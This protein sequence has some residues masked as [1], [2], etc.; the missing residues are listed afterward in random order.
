MT[1][2]P[3]RAQLKMKLQMI[4]P[5]KLIHK[6]SLQ[7]IGTV[8]LNCLK[9]PMIFFQ[10][11]WNAIRCRVVLTF[12]I[13]LTATSAKISISNNSELNIPLYLSLSVSH[14]H[15]IKQVVRTN[16]NCTLALR[17]QVLW[18]I[19]SNKSWALLHIESLHQNKKTHN[20]RL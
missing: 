1:Q 4:E 12:K 10:L 17:K 7:L 3:M 14:G 16:Q 19:Y 20:S 15:F 13:K 2:Q 11:I 5:A 6:Q 9:T 8:F 18:G